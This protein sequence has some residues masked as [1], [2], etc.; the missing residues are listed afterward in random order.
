V[1][2]KSGLGSLIAEVS[3]LLTI[4]FSLSHTHARTHTHTHCSLLWINDQLITQAAA[5]TTH[6]KHKGR[7]F[8]PSAGIEPAIPAIMRLR[9]LRPHGY[10]D[11]HF[12]LTEFKYEY[13][14][15]CFHRVL[16]ST[17]LPKYKILL[18][19]NAVRSYIIALRFSTA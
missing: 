13:N 10:R 3:R 11:R 6:N 7:T 17:L 19:E 9:R 12:R 2:T 1:G 4:S 18:Y 14:C 5:Y 15:M 16:P 8:M